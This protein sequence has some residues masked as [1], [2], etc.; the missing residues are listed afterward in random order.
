MNYQNVPRDNKVVKR[1]F[2]P[3]HGV[4]SWFDYSQIEPRLF[5]FYAAKGLGDPTIADWYREGRDVYREIAAR[6][7]KRP[8]DTITDD[9]RQ[10]GK[11]WFLMSLYG[12]GPRKMAAEIGMSHAEAKQ[13]YL[14]FHE[15]L[16]QIKGLSNPPPQSAGGWKHY[17]PG[18]IE[19]TLQRRGYLRTPWG[20]RLR[21]EQYGEHKMLNKLIQ[22]SAADLMKLS[23]NRV[24]AEL[25]G[26]RQLND[27]FVGRWHSR[28]VLTVHDEIG[29]DGPADEVE[30]LHEVVPA[31]MADYPIITEFVPVEVDHEVSPET[32][33]EKLSYEDWKETVGNRIPSAA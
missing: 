4:F 31:L 6:V 2:L 11:V 3:K 29:L 12:A 16:P 9:E 7:F 26:T 17:E 32:W 14:A 23:L 21:P 20:R 27:L 33:A 8:S 10:L 22:G 19:R 18:L 15:G 25:R 1:A 30:A 5:A 13:F 24:A 28:M